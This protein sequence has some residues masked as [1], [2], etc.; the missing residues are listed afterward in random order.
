VYDVTPYTDDTRLFRLM[1]ATRHPRSRWSGVTDHPS[2]RDSREPDV[3]SDSR[4]RSGQR[5]SH[6][7]AFGEQVTPMHALAREFV[8]LDNFTSTPVSYSGHAFSRGRVFQRLCRKIWPTNYGGR[9]GTYLNE[10]GG[11]MRTQY[12]TTR[13][14]PMVISGTSV[15]AKRT[16]RSYGEFAARDER[17][18]LV[19]E[20]SIDT[21]NAGAGRCAPC[22]TRRTRAP[23]LSAVTPQHS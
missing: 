2:L 21:C 16:V 5:R 7:H 22:R 23:A 20:L 9:G 18:A 14:R 3:R 4:S 11:Q 13:R 10:G 15:K 12:R 8:T 17:A 1:P 6:A 19:A